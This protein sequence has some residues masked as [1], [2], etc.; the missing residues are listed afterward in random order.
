M[1]IICY[2]TGTYRHII[3]NN[4]RRADGERIIDDASIRIVV[5]R[6]FS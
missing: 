6:A 4:I 5:T 3:I 1:Y 2:R